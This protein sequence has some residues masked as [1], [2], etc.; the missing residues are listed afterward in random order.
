V[1]AYAGRRVTSAS[2]ASTEEGRGQEVVVPSWGVSGASGHARSPSAM[3]GSETVGSPVSR[4]SEVVDVGAREGEGV[5]VVQIPPTY[6]SIA[7]AG[8]A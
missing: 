6:D 1:Y 7:N 8:R 3:M 5:V 4:R 2:V